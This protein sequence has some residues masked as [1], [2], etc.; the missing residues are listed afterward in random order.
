MNNR[1]PRIFRMNNDGYPCSKEIIFVNSESFFYGLRK[2][3]VHCGKVNTSPI[4]NISRLHN[5]RSAAAAAFT[6]PELFL[7]SAF[8][9]DQLQTATNVILNKLIPF[10]NR[11]F[12]IHEANI[13][14]ILKE[15]NSEL[16]L[17]GRTGLF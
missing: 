9:I 17:N 10:G 4:N 12:K 5:P 15:R 7:K 2:F 8:S 11:F 14:F 1:N 3:A 6:I 13:L 16:S